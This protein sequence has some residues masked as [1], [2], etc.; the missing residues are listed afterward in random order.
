MDY[1]GTI[2]T[3]NTS[4][5]YK[6]TA[7]GGATDWV[8][9][10]PAGLHQVHQEVDLHGCNYIEVKSLDADGDVVPTA[11]AL[12]PCHH[13][14]VYADNILKRG[15]GRGVF[16]AFQGNKTVTKPKNPVTLD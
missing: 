1:F 2:F 14:W 11:S 4:V 8:T 6:N 7:E 9:N 3:P 15:Q 5:W 12:P 10:F 16:S 13:N